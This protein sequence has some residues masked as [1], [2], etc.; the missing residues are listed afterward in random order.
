MKILILNW[1]DIKNPSSG[2]AEILT[3]EI[4]KGLVAKGHEVI[5]F[6]SEFKSSKP[7]EQID[8]IKI[9]RDGALDA[10]RLTGSV[11]F[12]AFRYYEKKLKGNVDLVIDEIHGMPFFIP[13]Y[14]KERKIALICEMTGDLWDFS[15]SFPFNLLGKFL[16][17]IYPKFYMSITI[18][19]I[20]ESSRQELINYGF[21]PRQIRVLPLGSNSNI[22]KNLPRKEKNPTLIFLSRLSKTKGIEDA[23]RSVSL[24]SKEFPKIKLWIV[25]KGSDEYEA[26]LRKQIAGL[27]LGNR[28][29]LLGYVSEKDKEKLLEKAHIL[30][31]P[32]IKEGWGLTIHEAGAKATPAIVYNVAGLRDVVKP[33]V[34]GIICKNNSPEDLAE[35]I[36]YLFKNNKA[37]LKLQKGAISE[38]E[39]H[40]WENTIRALLEII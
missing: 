34:N 17:K 23:I 18:L 4:A 10:R 20:S 27:K 1:R 38:R 30:I 28:I 14:V 5:Q 16:E 3:H 36:K 19:T 26:V 13:L 22:V 37:Y 8:G 15:V 40:S 35:N 7:E 32:S 33:N 11:Y 24:V 9:I 29:E 12:K 21:D 25:G 6:S 39:K 31:A 2:G